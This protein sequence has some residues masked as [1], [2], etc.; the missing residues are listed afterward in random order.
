LASFGGFCAGERRAQVG[1]GG[2][3]GFDLVR[4]CAL[5]APPL[6]V[7]DRGVERV[8]ADGQFL[9]ASCG[10]RYDGVVWVVVF[11]ESQRLA[12]ER[13]INVGEFGVH[14][15]QFGGVPVDALL[16]AS[17]PALAL[18]YGVGRIACQL[19]GDGTYGVASDL[20][21]AMSYPDG[22]APT[23]ERVH[24]TPVYE[25]LASLLIF[26]LLWRWRRRIPPVRLFAA[27]LVLAGIERFLIEFIRRNHAVLAGMT[28]PQLFA[29]AMVM[30]G[31]VLVVSPIS[32]RRKS[33]GTSLPAA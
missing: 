11:F 27:Y 3:H 1:Y 6:E 19:A 7:G 20:S 30:L 18:G 23:T 15:T 25:T 32:A 10:H 14:G 9:D 31:A 8:A 24:P 2:E 5:W 22:E 26:A 4:S 12:I 16:G 13:T 21:W 17:A 28:Q 29:T 33:A